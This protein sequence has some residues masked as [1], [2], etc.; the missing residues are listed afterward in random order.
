MEIKAIKKSTNP[1]Y[2]TVKEQK[3]T[4]LRFIMDNKKITLSLALVCLI[5][6]WK[7]VLAFDNTTLPG[8][9]VIPPIPGSEPTLISRLPRRNPI[10]FLFVINQLYCL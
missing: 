5:N 7:S 2:P 6:S 10:E 1:N 3:N 8:G 9:E 4:F